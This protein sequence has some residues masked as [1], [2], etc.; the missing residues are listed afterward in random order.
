MGDVEGLLGQGNKASVAEI[1]IQEIELVGDGWTTYTE[2][3]EFRVS[4]VKFEVSLE[5]QSKVSKRLLR[6]MELGREI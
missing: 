1:R 5:Y 2:N 6:G 3:I 4:H